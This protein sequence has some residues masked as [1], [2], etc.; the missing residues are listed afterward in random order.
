MT[1]LGTYYTYYYYS[2]TNTPREDS[3]WRFYWKV[4]LDS[5][6]TTNNSSSVKAYG[7]IQKYNV[8]GLAQDA[9]ADV[10]FNGTWYTVAGPSEGSSIVLIGTKTV[11]IN[12][13][14]DGTAT[15]TFDGRGKYWVGQA[16]YN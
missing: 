8:D 15:F 16:T 3:D 14:P 9:Y 2:G 5:Q 6:S 12:H 1:L 7:Y 4:Y 13:S 11:T 10:N